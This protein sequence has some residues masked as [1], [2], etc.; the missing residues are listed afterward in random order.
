MISDAFES[1][2]VI[3]VGGG[4]AGIAAAVAASDSGMKTLLLEKEYALGGM[5]TS[6]LVTCFAP[7]G[8]GIR[9]ISRGIAEKVRKEN[10]RAAYN[11]RDDDIGWV[12]ASPEDNKRFYDDLVIGTG[13]KVIFGVTVCGVEGE[14]GLI[15]SVI[16]ADGGGLKRY[17]G[18]FFIDATGDASLCYFA[19]LSFQPSDKDGDVQPATLCFIMSGICPEAYDRL[20]MNGGCPESPIHRIL[21]LKKWDLITDAHFC[22]DRLSSD[23]ISFNAG[24]LP[25]S[26]PSDPEQVTKAMILGRKMA[27]QYRDALSEVEPE[28]FGNAYLIQTASV[29]G[30]RESRRILGLYTLT[31]DDYLA[32][33]SFPDEIARNC[34]FIDV[35]D[36]NGKR[37]ETQEYLPGES[38]GIPYLCL[39]PIGSRNIL[40]A[41]RNISCDRIVLGSVR[42]MPNCLTMG[43]AAGRAAALALKSGVDAA[44]IDTDILRDNLRKSGAFLP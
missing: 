33:R 8:D 6:G 2:D 16:G 35:H 41:G 21:H 20:V 5:Q 10:N 17:K 7:F 25:I 13:V 14:A 15:S 4:P 12:T 44:E 43:E 11:T 29:L 34:Y 26:D 30:V 22:V 31:L 9:A 42:V 23:V 40:A 19:D 36:A 32:R 38:H 37:Y 28:A 24:H 18:R 1:V 27:K 3:V 39:V